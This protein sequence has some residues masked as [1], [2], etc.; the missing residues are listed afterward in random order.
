MPTPSILSVVSNVH[1]SRTEHKTKET[2]M[3]HTNI[4]PK[5]I[6]GG[7]PFDP[8]RYRVLFPDLWA[9]F[10]R[11]NYRNSVEVAYNFNV[12]DQTA[13]NWL[14]CISRPTGDKVALAAMSKP[15]EFAKHM[16]QA[17]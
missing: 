2:Q 7:A 5:N 15:A 11:V 8:H 17:A 1:H 4:L 14:N 12:T 10:L 16:G 6:C 13:L 3:S 9:E